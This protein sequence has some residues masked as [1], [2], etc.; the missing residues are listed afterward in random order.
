MNKAYIKYNIKCFFNYYCLEERI[1]K[2]NADCIVK[3]V[4]VNVGDSVRVE[5]ALIKLKIEN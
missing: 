3:D 1:I 5:Q 4:L 2:V